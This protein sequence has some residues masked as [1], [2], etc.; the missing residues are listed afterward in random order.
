MLRS[1]IR[2]EFIWNRAGILLDLDNFFYF[3]LNPKIRT[4]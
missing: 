1:G 4:K 3:V 2:L